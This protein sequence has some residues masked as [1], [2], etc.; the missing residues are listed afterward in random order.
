M[1]FDYNA[2]PIRRVINEQITVVD[3]V[4]ASGASVSGA[5]DLGYQRLAGIIMPAV[6][7]SAA[8]TFSASPDNSIFYDL[9]DDA[10]ERVIPSTSIGASRFFS[11]PYQ[12][13][14]MV[15]SLI[16]RSGTS[17]VP[18]NQAA[19]RTIRLVTV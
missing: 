15:R 3:A 2:V 9:Y 1:A 5:V 13:W 10:T 12:D 6:W 14:L 18:V 19:S 4:I 16:I 8:I 7:T 17:A 11:L